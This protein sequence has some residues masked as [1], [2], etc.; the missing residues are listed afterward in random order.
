MHLVL[1][2]TTL[3]Q[4]PG[5][6]FT[7]FLFSNVEQELVLPSGTKLTSN[8]RS[9]ISEVSSSRRCFAISSFGED[10]GPHHGLATVGLEWVHLSYSLKYIM[11]KAAFISFYSILFCR[12]F[13]QE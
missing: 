4:F 12:I 9:L 13:S 10:S 1:V 7:L 5:S 3:G 2:S 6:E 8:S 11:L